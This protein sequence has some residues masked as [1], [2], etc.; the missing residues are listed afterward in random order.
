MF[1]MLSQTFLVFSFFFFLSKVLRDIT[2][3]P[4]S[5][6][7]MLDNLCDKFSKDCSLIDWVKSQFSVCIFPLI[8]LNCI[9]YIDIL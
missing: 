3:F 9:G 2:Y 6:K 1:W 5:A 7:N 8:K 4:K